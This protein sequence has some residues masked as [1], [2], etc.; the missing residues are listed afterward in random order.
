MLIHCVSNLP[1]R[2][3]L[4]AMVLAVGDVD[5][6]VRVAA[7]VVRDVELAGSSRLAHER[8]QVPLGAYLCTR[9]L[10]SRRRRIDR[11]G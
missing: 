5:P 2:R 1:L 10:R 8:R 4:D 7:D 11:L 9:E 3:T 6:A